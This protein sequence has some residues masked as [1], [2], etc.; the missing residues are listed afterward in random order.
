MNA[1][2]LKTV[3]KRAIK[4]LRTGNDPLHLSSQDNCSEM[5]RIV[6]CWILQENPMTSAHI[7]KGENVMGIKKKCHDV[8]IVEKKNKFYLIDPTVWQFFKNKKNI[9]L[10]EKKAMKECMKFAEK[11]YGG[12][13][14]VSETINKNCFKNI[15]KW[16]NM[17]KSN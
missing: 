13:W 6:G 2:Y 9:L 15:K 17:I 3:Q 7:L 12:V 1:I 14:S 5:A 11:F 4:L 10:T 16:E 8:L